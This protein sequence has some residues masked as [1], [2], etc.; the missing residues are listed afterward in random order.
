[1]AKPE[2]EAMIPVAA[3]LGKNKFK[4]FHCRMIFS[5]R[6]G[7]WVNWNAMQVHLCIACDKLTLKRPERA[8]GGSH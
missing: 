3:K 5:Q 8:E 2:G 1:M 4:C 6:E 7:G